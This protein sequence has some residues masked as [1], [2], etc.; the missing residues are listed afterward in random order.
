MEVVATARYDNMVKAYVTFEDLEA[1]RIGKDLSFF[2]L[3]QH[4]G[5]YK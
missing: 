2:R 5:G 1:N 4:K 3:L